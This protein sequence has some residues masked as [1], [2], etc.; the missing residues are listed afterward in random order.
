[1]KTSSR[2]NN[3]DIK[4]CEINQDSLKP[5][6]MYYPKGKRN[7]ELI[8]WEDFGCNIRK[9]NTKFAENSKPNIKKDNDVQ[10][11][12]R[13]LTPI[14]LAI[15]TKDFN[16]KNQDTEK[17]IQNQYDEY[18]SFVT[19]DIIIITLSKNKNGWF[20]GYRARD[21]SCKLGLSHIDF[22]KVLF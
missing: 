18:L 6:F 1:M 19:E 11:D 3:C 14:G 16:S 10:W 7:Y 8:D 13:S 22:V 5:Q 17:G 2:N 15:A 12:C 9:K 20:E 4:L 21:N